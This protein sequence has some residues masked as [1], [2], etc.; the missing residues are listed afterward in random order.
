MINRPRGTRDIIHPES[1]L[2]QKINHIISELLNSNNYKQ[3]ILPTYEYQEIFSSL[4]K[5]T[6]IVRKEMFTF[7]DKKNRL[8]SLRP[9]GTMGI[10]R[11]VCQNN[12]IKNNNDF[13]K[14]YYWSNMFRYERPQHG[15][16]REFWQLGVELINTDGIRSDFEILHLAKMLLERLEIKNFYFSINYLGNEETRNNYKN[17][18][19]N[20]L[21]EKMNIL[22]EDCKI[23]YHNNPLRILDCEKCNLIKGIPNYK[24]TLNS[25]DI[26]YLESITSLLDKMK[27]DYIFDQKIVRGLDYYT[28]LVFEVK[29]KNEKKTIIGGGRY[30]DLFYKFTDG[31]K[32]FP[33]IGFAIGIDRL[34]NFLKETTTLNE[35]SE[36]RID[37][38]LLS[39]EEKT[40]FSFFLLKEELI[41]LQSRIIIELNLNSQNKKNTFNLIGSRN[42]KFVITIINNENDFFH[43]KNTD[44]R[45][46]FTINKNNAA[47][48]ILKIL[49][50]KEKGI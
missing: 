39:I 48:T 26:D 49:N 43:L 5:S 40:N 20:Y 23:R 21:E 28:G 35:K 15:R 11:S 45:E 4:G 12:L 29:L 34:I 22:C 41:N 2:Y 33:A 31:S 37:L 8:L 44:T 36:N 27:F 17:I 25:K 42:P 10:V 16:Y 50:L 14:L 6:D 9:E 3:I 1:S 7:Y 18:I 19:R 32:N 24:E 47:K 38:L 30:N 13:L 46:E